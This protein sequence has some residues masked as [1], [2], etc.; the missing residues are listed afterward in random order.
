MADNNT[1][2]GIPQ[3]KVDELVTAAKVEGAA[4]GAKAGVDME[5]ACRKVIA[6]NA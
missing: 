3:A 4:E 1:K 2:D 5:P 6:C